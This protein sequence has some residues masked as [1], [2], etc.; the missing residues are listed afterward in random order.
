MHLPLRRPRKKDLDGLIAGEEIILLNNN[1]INGS[2]ARITHLT[3]LLPA[4]L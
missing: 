2:G 4:S 1:L 3:P